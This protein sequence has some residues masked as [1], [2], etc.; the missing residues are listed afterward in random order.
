MSKLT[1]KPSVKDRL[2]DQGVAQFLE[3]GYHGAGLQDILQSVGV[4]K[5]SFYNYFTSKEAFGV[6]AIQHYIEPFI[7]LLDAWLQRPGLDAA[8]ALQGYFETLIGELE[9]RD[10]KGGCLLGNL[11]GEIGDTSEACRLALRQAVHRYRD[12]LGE[13]I[14]RGQREG[15]FRADK[16]AVDMAD[17]LADAWQGALLRMKIEQSVQPLRD[18]TGFLLKEYFRA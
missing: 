10:F 6:E 9:A 4:P 15:V 12:K 11:M 17:A 3:R 8:S 13:G 18:C 16:A 14:A 5:G 1:V 2:L 7:A